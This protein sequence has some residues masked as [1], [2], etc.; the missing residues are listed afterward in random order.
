MRPFRSADTLK[1]IQEI[2]SKFLLLSKRRTIAAD[3]ED[4]GKVSLTEYDIACLSTIFDRMLCV[5]AMTV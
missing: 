1:L 3:N 4:G 5:S 2:V